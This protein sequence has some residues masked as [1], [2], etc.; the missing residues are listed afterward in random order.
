MLTSFQPGGFSLHRSKLGASVR[1]T[2]SFHFL[3]SFRNFGNF[4]LYL[5]NN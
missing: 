4:N 5:T 2:Y 3:T 1:C